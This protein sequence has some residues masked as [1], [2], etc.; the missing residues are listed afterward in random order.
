MGL[1]EARAKAHF[2]WSRDIDE[3]DFNSEFLSN[4]VRGLYL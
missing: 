2:F 4:K 3:I 1:A